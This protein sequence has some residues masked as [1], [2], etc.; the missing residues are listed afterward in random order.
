MM[1]RTQIALDS[2][3][4]R[5]AKKRAAE[6]GVSLS[7]F[8]RQAVERELGEE[9]PEG[10]ISAIFGIFDSGGSDV[11]GHKDEYV[12]DA[13]RREYLRKAGRLDEE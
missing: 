9:R 3:Q 1:L 6:L 7:E 10:D 8:I 13:V 5:R 4:H 2:E 11:A 12:A